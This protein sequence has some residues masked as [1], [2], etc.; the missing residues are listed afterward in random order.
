MLEIA[1]RVP[2]ESEVSRLKPRLPDRDSR[3]G[4]SYGEK[5]ETFQMRVLSSD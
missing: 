5:S 3:P 1:E 4:S 2:P